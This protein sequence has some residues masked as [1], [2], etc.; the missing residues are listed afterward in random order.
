MGETTAM[1]KENKHVLFEIQSTITRSSTQAHIKHTF[2]VPEQT[3]AVYIDFAFD[4]SQVNDPSENEQIIQEA[5]DFYEIARSGA[6]QEEPVLNVLTLSIDDPEGFRGARHYHSPVQQMIIRKMGS[7]PGVLNKDNQAGLWSVTVSTHALVTKTC[8][9]SVQVY[10]IPDKSKTV[11]MQAIPWQSK[12]LTKSI[13]E[14]KE[15]LPAIAR[16]N[17]PSY[18]LPSELHTHTFHSDGKQSVL[19]MADVAKSMGLQALVVSDH[20]T[21]SPLQDIEEA[22]RESGLHI[23]YGLEWTTFYGHMLTIGYEKLTY[24][25]WRDIGPYDM[26]KGIAKIHEHGA[27][28]GMAHPFRIGYPIGTGCHWEF[29]VKGI[30][31]FDF[32]EVWNSVRPG[33]K[34]YNQR[35]FVYWTEL[36]NKGYRLTA[37]AGRDWHHNED[38]DP[39]PAITYVK[40]PDIW[41]PENN[42]QVA[43][44][45]TEKAENQFRLTFL[46]AIRS[47]RVSLSYG[48]PLDL[49]VFASW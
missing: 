4:P 39:L 28:A 3:D 35:A 27:L 46:A 2:F 36:L 44:E 26:E 33:A 24:T 19:E 20:N 41:A 49:T 5:H 22:K 15:K 47:G 42:S 12:P 31:I 10:R 25:D 7:T 37:T 14:N 43:S 40:M 8:Q 6:G 34:L 1:N 21:T 16:E 23:L 11:R 38:E 45:G 32:I 9:F 17:G 29:P 13:L 30:H 18:W 48:S